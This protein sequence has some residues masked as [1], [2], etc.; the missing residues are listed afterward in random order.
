[1]KILMLIDSFT[2]GGAQRQF[3]TI[4]KELHKEYDVTVV[5]Y[6]AITS[7]FEEELI[8]EGV[9]I[10]KI[11]KKSRFDIRFIFKLLK[12][13]KREKFSISISFL[14]TPN[15]YNVIAK[16]TRSV[17]KIIVSQRS[18]YFKETLSLKKRLR[19]SLLYFADH[20]TTN[21]ITQK[22]RMI[23]IFPFME[24][25]IH[26][27]PNIYKLTGSTDRILKR[28]EFIVL[29]NT[30]RNKNPLQL[31]K[32]IVEYNKIYGKPDFTIKWYGRISKNQ[33]DQ[34]ALDEGLKLL[35]L[36]NL[37]SCLAFVGITDNPKDKLLESDLLI[38]ISNFEGC[39][40]AVC[41]AMVY[42]TPVLVS[43]VCDSPYLIGNTR[44]FLVDVKSP[45][46][47]AKKIKEF[48]ES[49]NSRIKNMISEAFNFIQSEFNIQNAIGKLN[50]LINV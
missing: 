49:K 18:A 20:I 41:E 39:P 36:N 8:A 14:D 6:H 38:H 5:V 16:I 9:R 30:Q 35:K 2:V 12:F 32:A 29:S 46:D 7:H 31:C 42:K 22:E 1:M 3:T 47:I 44:G 43:N 24:K 4:A 23:D 13:I 50:S 40:N 10:E 27:L 37:S 33:I 11:L 26:Y 45:L 21:S 17:P 48:E 19:E 15:F 28:K 34:E 25:K